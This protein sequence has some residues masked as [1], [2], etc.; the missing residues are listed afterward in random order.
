MTMNSSGPISLGGAT[1]GQ[2]I[3]LE[4]GSPATST[5]SLNDTLVRTLANIPGL[6]TTITIP[7]DFYG[8]SISDAWFIVLSSPITMSAPGSSASF[9]LDNSSNIIFSFTA[10]NVAYQTSIA[11]TGTVNWTNNFTSPRGNT[12]NVAFSKADPSNPSL[13]KAFGAVSNSPAATSGSGQVFYNNVTTGA[14]TSYNEVNSNVPAGPGQVSWVNALVFN[15]TNT[16][17]ALRYSPGFPGSN[18][19]NM[20]QIV[21]PSY[22]NIANLSVPGYNGN[23]AAFA[24]NFQMEYA[25]TGKTTA[26]LSGR[27][28]KDGPSVGS[29][30]YV[31]SFTSANQDGSINWAFRL[32]NEMGRGGSTDTAPNIAISETYPK[33]ALASR[34]GNVYTNQGTPAPTP[35]ANTPS[36]NFICRFDKATGA[37]EETTGNLPAPA[38]SLVETIDLT[39]GMDSSG[40]FA[41]QVSNTGPTN[42]LRYFN[43]NSPITNFRSAIFNSSLG[44]FAT[45]FPA[46]GGI[47]EKDGYI[48][49]GF[50]RPANNTIGF[51]KIKS[52]GSSIT[53]GLNVTSPDGWNV[54]LTPTSNWTLYPF[55]AIPLTPT[56]LIASPALLSSAVPVARTGSPFSLSATKTTI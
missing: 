5:V 44:V 30:W 13:I 50:R 17:V 15:N 43:I 45:L 39:S 6:N 10:T 1:T 56:A 52:D 22:T 27:W 32:S 12:R 38:I 41:T 20:N 47:P 9:T 23:P 51:L 49:M 28:K 24:G 53:S 34:Y 4:I 7:T 42:T 40:N 2:S 16:V 29:N 37:I 48:Y 36:N 33:F 18:S 31:G 55:S 8:K 46:F 25:N 54:Q 21:N 26:I 35:S 3:N 11:P 19:T 14:M